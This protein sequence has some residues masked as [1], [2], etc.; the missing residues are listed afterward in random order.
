MIMNA[1]DKQIII[2]MITLY[3]RGKHK[4][5][6]V[7]CAEC[8]ELV[9]YAVDRLDRCCFGEDKPT[10]KACII[11][12]YS[13]KMKD[14]MRSVMRFSGPRMIFVHPIY[15]LKHL[16]KEYKRHNKNNI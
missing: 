1:K 9:R 5:T 8:E 2:K 13:P 7:L 14:K 15:T 3:C 6:N 11:H 4:Q 16:Y 10:C 12:C